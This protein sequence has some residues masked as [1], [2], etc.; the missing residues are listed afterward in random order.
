MSEPSVGTA[1]Y[2]TLPDRNN[3]GES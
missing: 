3:K 2:F 1:F